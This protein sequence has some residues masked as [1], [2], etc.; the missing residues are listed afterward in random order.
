MS[1]IDKILR[2]FN[3]KKDSLVNELTTVP[4]KTMSTGTFNNKYIT[5]HQYH[6]IDILYLPNDN[7]YKY[8]LVVVDIASKQLQIRPQK[9]KTAKETL[10]SIRSIYGSGRKTLPKPFILHADGGTEFMSVVKEWIKD[11]N[12][13]LRISTPFRHSQQS[14]VEAMNKIIGSAIIK[15]QTNDELINN[16]GELITEWTTFVP[17]IIDVLNNAIEKYTP[18][19][20][21]GKEPIKCL[22]SECY[23]YKEGT[24]VRVAL[25]RDDF[26]SGDI[27]WSK[28]KHTIIKVLL[29]PNRPIMYMVDGY[30]NAFY[31]NE[32]KPYR[33]LQG[34]KVVEKYEIEALR[35][36]FKKKGKIFYKVKWKGYRKLTDEPRS[37]LI[38]D[39]PD[40]VL[41]FESEYV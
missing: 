5:P 15:I 32:L 24:K 31:K 40:L 22:K 37:S 1:K 19:R 13:N 26:R 9:T 20:Y 30:R 17:D 34:E 28:Q 11:N 6:Q 10:R 18:K 7:G 33:E 39:V 21:T 12:I 41:E 14:V 2:K 16:D 8:A 27:R 3:I 35:K 29:L 36:R 25:K 4:K 23:A 38:R